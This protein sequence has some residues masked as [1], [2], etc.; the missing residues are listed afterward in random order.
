MKNTTAL[1][2][3]ARNLLLNCAGLKAGMRVAFVAEDPALG[4]YDS[5]APSAV[6]AEARNLGAQVVTI[7]VGD[8]ADGLTSEAEKLIADQDMVIFFTRIGDQDRFEER[9]TDQTVVMSYARTAP[10]LASAFGRLDHRAMMAF[11]AGVDDVFAAARQ[12]EISC[13]LGTHLTAQLSPIASGE[14]G[15][16]TVRRFPLGV[17]RPVSAQAFEGRV[18]LTRY[19]TP[20]GSRAYLPA[21]IALPAPEAEPPLTAHISAGRIQS[22]QG[23]AAAVSTVE[24]HYA[25]VAGLFGIDARA[26]HSWH[27]GLHPGCGYNKSIDDD[28]DLWSNNVFNSPVFA[29]FHTCGGYAPGE[30]SWMVA[31]PTITVDGQALWNSGRLEPEAFSSLTN[32]LTEWPDLADALKAPYPNVGL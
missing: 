24:E 11:K 2:D 14:A 30:I 29:H 26:I 20:T 8:P 31:H 28:P 15:E 27:A 10:V 25:H 5:E 21:A 1:T 13:P 4:W 6:A 9:P 12:I 23:P 22:Y 7:P 3:G 32:I 16:V 17:P 18:V 19:L